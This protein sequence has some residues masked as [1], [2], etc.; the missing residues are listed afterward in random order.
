M[1]QPEAETERIW[2]L[3]TTSFTEEATEFSKKEN[4]KVSN[5]F[6]LEK[7]NFMCQSAL[8]PHQ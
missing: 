1:M 2:K 8:A 3:N 7:D 6:S 5:D 4:T